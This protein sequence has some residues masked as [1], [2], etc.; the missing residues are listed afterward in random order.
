MPE[1]KHAFIR[2]L[3]SQGRTVWAV[4]DGINDAPQLAQ[5]DVSVAVGSGAPLAQAGADI[6]MTSASLLP[7]AA[8]IR[9]AKKT[10]T[11]IRQN[12]A[13]AFVY[14]LVA[15]PVAAMGLVNPWVAGIGMALSSL[16]V[17]LNAWRLRKVV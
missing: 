15:I 9:H 17:T 16:G 4:G 8:C 12:L 10:K 13:W 7:L 14:N 6:V 1:E 2:S 3:Q 11:V 5:A